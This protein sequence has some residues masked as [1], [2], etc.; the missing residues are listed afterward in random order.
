MFCAAN[1]KLL[2]NPAPPIISAFSKPFTKLTAK[3]VWLPL[4]LPDYQ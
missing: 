4:S 2:S 3:A 1:L